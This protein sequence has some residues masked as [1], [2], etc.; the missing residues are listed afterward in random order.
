LGAFQSSGNEN[1][2]KQSI[3]RLHTYIHTY[4]LVGEQSR[5]VIPSLVGRKG[6]RKEVVAQTTPFHHIFFQIRSQ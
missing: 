1:C 3:K 6:G 2:S 4:I 5:I